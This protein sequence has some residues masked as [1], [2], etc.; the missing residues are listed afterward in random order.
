M[1]FK[2]LGMDYEP[3]RDFY[4]GR[5]YLHL[6]DYGLLHTYFRIDPE[7]NAVQRRVKPVQGDFYWMYEDDVE[8]FVS[9]LQNQH[10]YVPIWYDKWDVERPRYEDAL[11]NVGRL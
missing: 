10:M 4:T 7:K 6:K 9:W 3:P 5:L 8:Y 11:E 1:Q 2:F